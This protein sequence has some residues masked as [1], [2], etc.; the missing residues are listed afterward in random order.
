MCVSVCAHAQECGCLTN[1]VSEKEVGQ[2]VKDGASRVGM[3]KQSPPPPNYPP[4]AP[5]VLPLSSVSLGWRQ[6]EVSVL[7]APGTRG[8][9]REETLFLSAPK[10]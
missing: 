6:G 7:V 2:N 3:V 5:A 1:L 4:C 9:D 8:E 10:A